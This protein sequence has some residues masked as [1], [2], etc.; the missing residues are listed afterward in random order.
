MVVYR[1]QYLLYIK[2][3]KQRSGQHKQHTVRKEEANLNTLER[4]KE[5]YHFKRDNLSAKGSSMKQGIV[6]AHSNISNSSVW[7]T[8]AISFAMIISLSLTCIN[9]NVA[10]VVF[11]NILQKIK[12]CSKLLL[13]YE[14]FIG[15][16][17]TE[18]HTR[19]EFTLRT[20]SRS[21]GMEGEG[22]PKRVCRVLAELSRWGPKMLI[23]YSLDCVFVVFSLF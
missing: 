5:T 13:Q 9:R 1:S 17:H 2:N 21:E 15:F 18:V 16:G 3:C 19:H 4:K 12:L 6:L 7:V 10:T 8:L 11:T 20:T 23:F 22:Y 14:T